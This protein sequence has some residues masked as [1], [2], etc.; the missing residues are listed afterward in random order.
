MIATDFIPKEF[1]QDYNRRIDNVDIFYIGEW[2]KGIAIAYSKYNGRLVPNLISIKGELL[3]EGFACYYYVE[4]IYRTS[5]GYYVVTE[6]RDCSAPGKDSDYRGPFIKYVISEDGKEKILY[7]EFSRRRFVNH[8][9][10]PRAK[11]VFETTDMGCRIVRH[12]NTFY[13]IETLENIFTIPKK[14]K[15]ESIFISKMC[16]LSVPSDN[17]DFIVKVQNRNIVDYVDIKNTERIVDLINK[18]NDLSIIKY[19]AQNDS[20]VMNILRKQYNNNKEKEEL[21]ISQYRYKSISDI[22]ITLEEFKDNFI[23]SDIESLIIRNLKQVIEEYNMKYGEINHIVNL[24]K[25]EGTCGSYLECALYIDFFILRLRN[26]SGAWFYRFYDYNGKSLSDNYFLNVKAPK[27][28][29]NFDLNINNHTFFYNRGLISIQD[30][31]LYYNEYPDYISNT[32]QSR[33]LIDNYFINDGVV[34]DVFF[35]KQEVEYTDVSI[36]EVIKNYLYRMEPDFDVSVIDCGGPDKGIF[37]ADL[38]KIN[39][40]CFLPIPKKLDFIQSELYFRERNR[41][42]HINGIELIGNYKNGDEDIYSLY[43]FECRPQGFCDT[44]GKIYYDFNPDKIVW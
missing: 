5:K 20:P 39:G 40:K 18:T 26:K 41:P 44:R 7:T 38:R 15:V 2:R 28:D 11:N 19:C 16:M 30:G 32:Y 35:N 14:F 3:Y 36:K 1:L 27:G 23:I 37:V 10:N 13:D 25:E 9:F 8:W 17:R 34:Y 21:K 24:R 12:N 22:N 33:Y 29:I 4:D 31:E 42:N 6:Y 43:L